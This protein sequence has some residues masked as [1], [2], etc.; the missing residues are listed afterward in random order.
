MMNSS[1]GDA[2]RALSVRLRIRAMVCD[3]WAP[4]LVLGGYPL[5]GAG[6]S[7]GISPLGAVIPHPYGGAVEGP[8]RSQVEPYS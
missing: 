1:H 7:P 8:R 2:T 3:R 6:D 5:T 4:P